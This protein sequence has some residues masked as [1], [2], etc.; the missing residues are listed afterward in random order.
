MVSAGTRAL[1]SFDRIG[2]AADSSYDVI[3]EGAAGAADAMERAAAATDYWT[4][5]IGNYDRETA[6]AVDSTEELADMG[7]VTGEALNHLGN[8]LGDAADDLEDFGNE[9]E[10]ARDDAEDFGE[11]S[12]SAVEGL[13][14]IGRA[15]V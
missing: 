5:R 3:S 13:D 12:Q 6:Q 14:K 1:D 15:H 10:D 2:A 11:R 8:A 9:V 7:Y 4:D